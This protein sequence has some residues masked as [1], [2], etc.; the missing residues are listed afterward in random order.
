MN[1]NQWI[2][3]A[4]GILVITFFIYGDSA[5]ALFRQSSQPVPNTMMNQNP[6]TQALQIQ[7]IEVG[8]GAEATVG[9]MVTVHYTGMLTDGRVFD[10]SAGRAPFSLRLGTGQVIKGWDM[11]LQGMKVGGKRRLIIPP[12]L[13][14]GDQQVGPL[15]G[16]NS[17]LVF[18]VELIKVEK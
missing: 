7:D 8:T 16:P 10:S 15:I 17:T 12:Q 6:T 11:G 9:S 13:A 1:R 18:D 4:T 2:A 3:V 14:Y 5:M